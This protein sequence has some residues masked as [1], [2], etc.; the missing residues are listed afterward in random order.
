VELAGTAQDTD[1]QVVSV[2]WTQQEGAAV[3]L[4]NAN[5]LTATTSEITAAG[6]Y[7]FRLAATDD[8]GEVGYSDVTIYANTKEQTLVAKADFVKF[9]VTNQT[10]PALI[11]T[12][13]NRIDIEVKIQNNN[14]VMVPAFELSPRATSRVNGILQTSG[15]SEHDFTNPVSYTVMAADSLTEK[16]WTVHV[17]G[18]EPNPEPGAPAG[19]S[20]PVFPLFFSP[21]ADGQNDTWSIGNFSSIG[22]CTLEVFARNGQLVFRNSAFENNWDGASNGRPVVSGDYYY[23]ISRQGVQI[24]SGSLRI[25]R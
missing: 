2:A 14:Y 25:I 17:A 1:G 4:V 10:E 7:V 6:I 24:T 18:V 21:N 19:P 23:L 12:V 3:T 11:D 9:A 13:R 22:T 16:I 20:T 5:T 15:V 8:K